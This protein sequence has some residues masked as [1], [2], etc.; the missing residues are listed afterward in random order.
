MDAITTHMLGPLDVSGDIGL[1][2][3]GRRVISAEVTTSGTSDHR[4][5]LT[6]LVRDSRAVSWWMATIEPNGS[7]VPTLWT[8]L[9]IHVAGWASRQVTHGQLRQR[10]ERV[11]KSVLGAIESGHLAYVRTALFDLAC[12]VEIESDHE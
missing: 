5:L 7:V 9:D 8:D 2:S 4:P 6:V 12:R 3:D 1:L 10:Y 11:Y